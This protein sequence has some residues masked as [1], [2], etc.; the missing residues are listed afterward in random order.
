MEQGTLPLVVAWSC[1]RV[2]LLRM[3][4]RQ[5]KRRKNKFLL[6]TFL[7]IGLSLSDM[8]RR[9]DQRTAVHYEQA[10]RCA[11]N[12]ADKCCQGR[13]RLGRTCMFLNGALQCENGDDQTRGSSL[14]SAIDRY[15]VNEMAVSP[16]IREP[17]FNTDFGEWIAWARDLITADPGIP[18]KKVTRWCVFSETAQRL[19]PRMN[20]TDFHQTLDSRW[21]SRVLSKVTEKTHHKEEKRGSFAWMDG[22]MWDGW[23]IFDLRKTEPR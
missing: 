17:W 23:A 19:G 20:L 2:E 5:K 8:Q 13:W 21:V 12:I 10:K 22:R 14:L 9:Y 15:A 16:N 7:G 6:Y 4:N 11:E 18:A 1:G 3:M